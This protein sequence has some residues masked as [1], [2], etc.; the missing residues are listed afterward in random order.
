M[1]ST[2]LLRGHGEAKR[3]QALWPQPSQVCLDVYMP[4]PPQCP[5]CLYP[6]FTVGPLAWG[7]SGL[8]PQPACL[9]LGT[10]QFSISSRFFQHL[11]FLADLAGAG[12]A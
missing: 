5:V 11:S 3:S 8:S 2:E 10:A 12:R 1:S 6:H 7:F 4:P 9:L